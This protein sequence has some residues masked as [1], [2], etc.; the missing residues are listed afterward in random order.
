MRI[1]KV[2]TCMNSCSENIVLIVRVLNDYIYWVYFLRHL[3][4]LILCVSGD[5]FF[6]IGGYAP[7]LSLSSRE[8]AYAVAS[9]TGKAAPGP[10]HYNVSQAQ[11]CL[12]CY[13]WLS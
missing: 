1:K 9:D 11:V 13:N 12:W 8:S 3:S 7:F 5:F 4:D 10:A 2:T 6:F